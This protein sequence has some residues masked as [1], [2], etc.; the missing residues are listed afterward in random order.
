MSGPI[1]FP[2]NTRE[3]D[4]ADLCA[5]TPEH[6]AARRQL[7][8]LEHCRSHP[9]RWAAWDLL[10]RVAPFVRWRSPLEKEPTP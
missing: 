10:R 7:R 5:T 6:S 3:P 4:L 8:A 9:L 1:R 2:I